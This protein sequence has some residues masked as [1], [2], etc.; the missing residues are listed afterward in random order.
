MADTNKKK[1]KLKHTNILHNGTLCKI[2]D[3]LELTDVQAARLTDFIEL[4]EE[5]KTTQNKNTNKTKSDKQ[6]SDDDK[7]GEDS[8]GGNDGE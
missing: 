4:V 7:S 6:K 3:I 2:G 5:Q 1:Y 8:T